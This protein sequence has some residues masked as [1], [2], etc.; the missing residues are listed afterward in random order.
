MVQSDD[1]YSN[2]E[3]DEDDSE[4][5]DTKKGHLN[6]PLENVDVST[7]KKESEVAKNENDDAEKKNES[8]GGY[9]SIDEDNDVVE[10]EVEKQ[11]QKSLKSASIKSALEENKLSDRNAT[12]QREI[13][14]LSIDKKDDEDNLNNS[15]QLIDLSP[16]NSSKQVVSWKGQDSRKVEQTEKSQKS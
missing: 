7:V 5:E 4:K 16:K 6:L 8:Q 12:S 1:N 10:Q 13:K 2:F 3:E 14:T 9:T 15:Q 11:F